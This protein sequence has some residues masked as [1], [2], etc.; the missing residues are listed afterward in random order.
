V[1]SFERK[2]NVMNLGQNARLLGYVQVRVGS[3]TYA[4]AVQ[5]VHFEKDVETRAPAG[6]FFSE[7]SGQ[8]GILVDGDASESDVQAQIMEASQEAVRHISKKFL[9]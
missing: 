4:L 9:N 5:A 1:L 7:E 6:G 2:V 3:E 8:L